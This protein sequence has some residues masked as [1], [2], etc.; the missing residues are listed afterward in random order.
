M[1][2]KLRL[3]MLR[4]G[5]TVSFLAKKI[6]MSEKSLRNKLNGLTE[7]RWSEIKKIRDAVAR[8]MSIE[9]LFEQDERNET[10]KNNSDAK[11]GNEVL[12]IWN[13]KRTDQK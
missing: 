9:E 2:C 6:G 10:K 3:E 4:K 13:N 11:Q 5:I 7:F 8:G 1:F 12:C